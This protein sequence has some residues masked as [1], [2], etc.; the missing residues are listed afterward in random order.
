VK[1]QQSIALQNITLSNKGS[2]R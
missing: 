2:N 1:A